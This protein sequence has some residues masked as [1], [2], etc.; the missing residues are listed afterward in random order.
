MARRERPLDP[1]ASPLQAFAHDLREVRRAAGNPQ[2]RAL[3]KAAGYSPSALSA[4]AG[5]VTLPS[6]AV[7]LAYVGACGGDM[8]AW[9]TRWESLA[10]HQQ[11]TILRQLPMDVPAFTGRSEELVALDTL[12][13]TTKRGN[14]PVGISVICGPGGVGKTALAV[15]WAH[16]V[17]RR[18]TDG[19]LY[20]DLRG[21][22]VDA[23]TPPGDALAVLLHGLGV[24]QAEIPSTVDGRAAMYRS[25]IADRRML[26]VI[27]NARNAP[28]VR[29]LLPGTPS[30]FVIVTS[31]D[32]L[33]G[34]VVRHGAQRTELGLLPLADAIALLRT[35][36]G[37][38]VDTEP[39]AAQALAGRCARLPLTLRIAAELAANKPH[40]KLAE[41]V[42]DLAD[43]RRRLDA[44]DSDSDEQCATRMVFSWSY[45]NLPPI[46]ARAFRLLGASPAT[47]FDAAALAA[48]L[49]CDLPTT[50]RAL[51]LLAQAH[52]VTPIGA[53]RFEM[54]DLLA[55]YARECADDD[56]DPDSALTRLFDH[57]LATASVAADLISPHDNHRRPRIPPPNLTPPRDADAAR[58]WLDTE[59]ANL[60]AVI[61]HAAKRGWP[62]HATQ[63]AAT[64]GGYL[65]D[66]AHYDEAIAAQSDALNA[67][68][69]VDDRAA[70]AL[71]WH[72]LGMACGQLGRYDEAVAHYARA[73]AIRRELK[74]RPGEA[75]T[76]NNFSA[77]EMLWGRFDAAL[78]LNV[79]ALT[80]RHEIGDRAGEAVTLG[81]MA[82]A[83]VHLHQID[84]A[85]A[86]YQRA[87]AIHRE[88]G[89]RIGEAFVLN[90]IGRALSSAGRYQESLDHLTLAMAIFKQIDHRS[91]IG[92]VRD[93][94]GITCAGLGHL[95]ES[96]EHHQEAL[97]V[98]RATRYRVGEAESLDHLGIRYRQCGRH[99][100]AM[101]CHAQSIAIARAIGNGGLEATALNNLGETQ[102]AAGNPADA[103]ASHAAALTL[104]QELGNRHEQERAQRGL[105]QIL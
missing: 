14:R 3:A 28:Q 26:V 57:L 81:N 79:Q 52:L 19:Q 80:I 71:A 104:A 24:G 39:D 75:A 46:G 72:R 13:A 42:D 65:H 4:A 61:A 103:R 37:E 21:Y 30:C 84:E 64:I 18:F 44:F 43:Q 40:A 17:A 83:Y 90:G 101:Q 62:Q 22:D 45:R 20:V 70:E 92:Y 98:H 77:T 86:H 47:G 15:H 95:T 1:G 53:S 16:R 32:S 27:D 38:R 12:L 60:L 58:R 87:L 66:G 85:L 89:H 8:T 100:E 68:R 55:A 93:E 82:T 2:Y 51:H 6:L 74:D 41:L 94:M 11:Q 91:G 96:I 67:A 54:H 48:L 49:G 36:I 99:L 63:L 7:T 73:L 31:R 29:P 102:R 23:P 33:P 59:K 35:L 56:P 97:A 10:A 25:L 5:G 9:Q 34:L 69:T 78:E 50:G 105:S 88:V 76:L